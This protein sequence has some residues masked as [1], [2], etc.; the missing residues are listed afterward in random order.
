MGYP[1][2]YP[3]DYSGEINISQNQYDKKDLEWYIN[4][5]EESILQSILGC[6]MS[7]ELILDLDSNNEPQQD[8]FIA[9]W[10]KFCIDDKECNDFFYDNY[11]PW[12]NKN[13]VWKSEGILSL[14][15][16]QIYF[17]YTRDQPNKNTITGNVK[18]ENNTS[19]LVVNNASNIKRNYNKSIMWQNAI[20]WYIKKNPDNYDY[21]NFNGEKI[22]YTSTVI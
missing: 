4:E 19:S 17:F 12:F 20:Q 11:Y 14:I 3:E 21:S 8:K 10:D 5:Y 9:I 1:L 22:E 16:Y 2:T 7:N 15:K 13:K 18:N 6:E